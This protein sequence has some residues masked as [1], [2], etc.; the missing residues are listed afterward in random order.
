MIKIGNHR[1]RLTDTELNVI[2]QRAAQ[3]GIVVNSVS[4][5]SELLEAIINGLGE[6]IIEDML[7]FLV[8]REALA[9]PSD[10]K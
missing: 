8:S 7:A 9:H 3:N 10:E 2:R 6:A 5:E 4:T 1:I